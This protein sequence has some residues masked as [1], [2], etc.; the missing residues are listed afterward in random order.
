MPAKDQEGQ[1]AG[2]K[3][4]T[5]KVVED[6]PAKAHA[7][8]PK[9]KPKKKLSALN[10]AARVSGRNEE[11]DDHPRDGRRHGRP[12]DI[13]TS[14]GGATPWA[15]LYSALLREIAAKGKEA[16]FTKTE[17]GHFAAAK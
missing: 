9:A 15:T 13:W 5:I 17:R 12:R 16:R 10:A 7:K 4:R 3:P 11:A 6:T 8:E 1:E 14:P 2:P